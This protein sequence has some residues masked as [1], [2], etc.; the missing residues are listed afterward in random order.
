MF[1]SRHR[2]GLEKIWVQWILFLFI[3]THLLNNNNKVYAAFVNFT[4]SFDYIVRDAIWCKLIKIGIRGKMLDTIRSMYNSVRLRIRY[5][6]TLSE[7]CICTQFLEACEICTQ[8]LNLPCRVVVLCI[9]SIY[10]ACQGRSLRRFL[11][12]HYLIFFSVFKFVLRFKG[13]NS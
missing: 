5:D 7:D 1:I 11:S 13:G 6:N 4:K 9:L 12:F 8:F 2:Q 3:I 10:S